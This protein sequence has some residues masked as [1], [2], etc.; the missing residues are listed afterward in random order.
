MNRIPSLRRTLTA[1][2][3]GWLLAAALAAPAAASHP[4]YAPT[5][6][7]IGDVGEDLCT[8]FDTEGEASWPAVHAPQVPSV[9]ISGTAVISHAPPETICLS[10]VPFPRHIEF[11]GYI[12]D[13]PVAEHAVP[14]KVA[15]DGGGFPGSGFE[16][17][18]S[19]V[20]PSG[21]PIDYVTAAICKDGIADDSSWEDDCTEAVVIVPGGQG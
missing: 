13:E 12:R 20:A 6:F 1:L 9:E 17:E 10:V 19:L 14:F 2:A 5:P 7:K 15:D 18:F 8:Y 21:N 16:Y 3:A 4:Q 11:I